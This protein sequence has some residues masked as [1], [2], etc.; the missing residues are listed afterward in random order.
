MV[1]SKT[2]QSFSDRNPEAIALLVI[3]LLAA[4]GFFVVET[5]RQI[6]QGNNPLPAL[7]GAL[8]PPLVISGAFLSVHLLLRFRNVEMEQVLLPAVCLLFTL[9]MVMIWRLRGAEGAWQQ[10]LRGLVPGLFIAGALV[11]RPRIIERVRQWAIPI[12]VAGLILPF[13]T[14]LFGVVDETGARLALKLGPLPPIQTSEFLKVSLVIFLAWYI[15]REGQ[16]VEGRAR[17]VLV[18]LRLPALRYFLPGILFVSLSTLALVM[19]SD[20]GAVLIMGFLFVG[21]LYAGFETRLFAAIAAIGLALALLV[22]LVLALAWEVP[23]VIRYRFLAFM[24]PWSTAAILEN[25]LPTGIT[26][27]QGP[28]YQIQQSIYAVIAGGLTGRGLGF[29][30]PEFI[31][32][33]HSD[34]IFAAVVEE[35]GAITGIAVL[36]LFTL[37]MLRMLR[38]ALVLPRGQVFERLLLI[39]FGIHLFTQVFVM[40]GG[41]LNLLPLTGVTIPFMSLGGIALLVNLAEVGAALALIQ[42]LETSAP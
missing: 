5:A 18:W 39:G 10:L 17:P 15:E 14:A 42:R 40:A 19:M 36:A 23:T 16:A 26:I 25:G 28:G 30:T 2:T 35:L 12:S 27:S 3:F 21:M 13:A 20:F 34:F 22:G 41:T 37:V 4:L 6:Q 11:L 31:P 32:L 9:G 33:A 29:G 1:K 7:P 24:D 8:L 38:A